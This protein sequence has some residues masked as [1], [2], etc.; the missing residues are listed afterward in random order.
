MS[1]SLKGLPCFS[2]SF[3]RSSSLVLKSGR[4]TYTLFGN[5]RRAASSSSCGRFVAAITTI[6]SDSEFAGRPSNWTRNSVFKRRVASCS[7]LLRSES[8]ES[9]SSM[10][11]IDGCISLATANKALTSF[12]PSPTYL[13]V[14]VAADM[15]KKVAEHS[16][17][18]ALASSVLP[19]PGGPKSSKPL[20]GVRKPVKSSGR[21][22]GSITISWSACLATS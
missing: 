9:T 14:K 10:K 22:D 17:A 11:I 3:L 20:A 21:T 7:P 5:R 18:T 15:L 19:L 12:S 8:N 4:V 6:L 13:L 2:N 1:A 16:V